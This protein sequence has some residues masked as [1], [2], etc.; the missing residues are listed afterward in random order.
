MLLY[1]PT[2][3]VYTGKHLST[4]IWAC[5][6]LREGLWGGLWLLSCSKG[7]ASLLSSVSIVAALLKLK[8]PPT[9]HRTGL[10][11]DEGWDETV[12]ESLL[13][14]HFNVTC[15]FIFHIYLYWLSINSAEDGRYCT[16][17]R[18]LSIHSIHI[19]TVH[20]RTV[21]VPNTVCGWMWRVCGD[22][23]KRCVCD[24]KLKWWL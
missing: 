14:C 11:C 10:G 24:V 16:R 7:V 3:Y 13:N 4:S 5:F 12:F 22:S 15:V 6:T 17:G 8:K 19:Y 20:R 2:C 1:T 21:P 9:R 23:G 18:L